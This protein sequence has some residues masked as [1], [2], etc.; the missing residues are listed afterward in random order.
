MTGSRRERA[1]LE[2]T[3]TLHLDLRMAGGK[4][5]TVTNE[6]PLWVVPRP[7]LPQRLAL[8]GP[9]RYDHD[10]NRLRREFEAEPMDTAPLTVPFLSEAVS[11][12]VLERT[13]AGGRGLVWL[14]RYDSRF[15][16]RLAFWREAIHVFEP[17]R[18]WERAPQAGYAD[19]RF[20]SVATDIAL[21]LGRLQDWLGPAARCRPVWR[22]FDARQLTWAEHVVEVE[23]GAGRLF[24]TG[25]RFEG[26]LGQQPDTFDANPMGA[27]MLTSLLA[28]VT[29]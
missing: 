1:P 9:L 22:R 17:H 25:L 13:R 6:W 10:L 11:A 5:R 20:F 19:M 24:L 3:L 27:W 8:A 18:L 7:E 2:L 15:T 26:G 4:T 29:P 14:R 23:Y 21:D 16:R 28:E 12:E